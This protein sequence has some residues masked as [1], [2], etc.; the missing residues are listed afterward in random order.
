MKS[1][2]TLA[3]L[4]LVGMVAG[5]G[6][7]IFSGWVT[8]QKVDILISEKVKEELRKQMANNN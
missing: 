6:V 1:K 2:K 8:E 5:Y 4:G 7:S 3:V